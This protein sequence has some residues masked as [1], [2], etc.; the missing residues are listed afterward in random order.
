MA[1]DLGSVFRFLAPRRRTAGGTS[2]TPT[3]RPANTTTALSLPDYRD[4][5]RDV[6]DERLSAAD[7]RPFLE[8]LFR[9][10]PDVSAA[11]NAY[12]TVADTEPMFFIK[13]V[14]GEYDREAYRTL[15]TLLNVLSHQADMTK[16]Y[17]D[18]PGLAGVCETLRHMILLRGAIAGE[19]VMDKTL[20]PQELR[21]IDP[22]SIRWFER[23]AGVR[24]PV[25]RVQGRNDDI[26]LDIPTFFWATF[27]QSPV[28]AYPTPP[29]VSAINTIASRQRVIND[30]YRILAATGYPRIDVQ[31]LEDVLTRAAPPSVRNNAVE[32][33]TWVNARIAEIRAQFAAIRPEESFVHTDSVAVKILNDKAPGVGVNVESI[34]GVLNAQNQAGLKSV[35]TIL[36]RGESGVNTASVE[37]RVFSLNADALNQPLARMLSRAF[38]VALQIAGHPVFV[39]CRFRKAELRPSLELEPQLVMRQGRL[40]D[41]LSLGLMTDEE[42]HI[43]MYGRPPPEGAPQ[44]SGTNF[45]TPAS[46]PDTSDVSPNADP[47]GRALTPDGSES[48]RSNATT[49]RRPA[50]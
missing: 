19:L 13:N 29:F 7:A 4:Y 16:G 42:F 41:A 50:R 30:L 36:G 23:Q 44:L 35:S 11:V 32:I 6:F 21:V 28:S 45:R 37:S 22:A 47:Q 20:V 25:Q 2:S 24:K 17:E 40:L 34:I 14:N 9:N 26:N 1:I 12:L 39:E 43:E 10:D 5:L 3:F 27:R 15:D 8:L 46:T 49:R 18:K 31:V 38:T 33:R 48:A